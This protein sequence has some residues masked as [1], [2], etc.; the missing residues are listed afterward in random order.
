MV[1]LQQLNKIFKK[2]TQNLQSNIQLMSFIKKM[3][4]IIFVYPVKNYKV[5]EEMIFSY[6]LIERYLLKIN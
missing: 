3:V 1:I 6:I 4:F 5:N 2:T